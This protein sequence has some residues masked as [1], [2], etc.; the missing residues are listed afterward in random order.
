[1]RYVCIWHL[2]PSRWKHVVHFDHDVKIST[3]NVV[4]CQEHLLVIHR[5][6]ASCGVC[7]LVTLDWL[8]LWCVCVCV[9][10]CVCMVGRRPEGQATRDEQKLRQYAE[11]FPGF[12]QESRPRS[13][14]W[15]TRQLEQLE[16]YASGT[17]MLLSSQVGGVCETEC[18]S[19]IV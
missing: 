15:S 16:K 3:G 4:A 14:A 2:G 12:S 17:G 10:V 6:N 13:S 9:T 7:Y 5:S 11:E 18:P 8:V 19:G 1:V